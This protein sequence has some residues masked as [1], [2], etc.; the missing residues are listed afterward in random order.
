MAL[1]INFIAFQAGWFAAVLS[2][3]A[4]RPAL[5][6]GVMLAVIGLHLYRSPR[7]AQEI[8]LIG[9]CGLIG[10]VWDSALVTA[11]WVS[12]ASGMLAEGLAPYWIVG[13]W[14]LFATTMN[15]SLGWL[16]GR[17]ALAVI[18][19]AVGGP[20]AYLTGQKLGG[21][22]LVDVVAALVALA[23]GW[24]VMMPLLLRLAERFDGASE[25]PAGHKRRGLVFD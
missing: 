1:F 10:G 23:A 19:G 15:V 20:L 6:F 2:A 12:Y 13:M 9:L 24:G 14:M 17:T 22:V 11:G 4:G 5:G 16:K 7:P 21:I 3:A 18:F 25:R 8:A